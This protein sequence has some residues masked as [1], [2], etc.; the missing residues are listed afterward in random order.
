MEF[1]S[2]GPRNTV[3]SVYC[4]Y[5][6]QRKLISF[7]NL[8]SSQQRNDSSSLWK[9]C[10]QPS[11]AQGLSLCRVKRR[12]QGHGWAQTDSGGT[13]GERCWD[14]NLI[15]LPRKS[16]SG[17]RDSSMQNKTTSAILRAS[18][19]YKA[20]NTKIIKQSLT[21]H[22]DTEPVFPCTGKKIIF[23]FFSFL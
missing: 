9:S 17:Q 14:C 3:L 1:P 7:C 12:T 6:C 8:F 5:S 4:I 16:P 22:T 18:S 2:F 15:G 20:I 13:Q 21:Y 23:L 10:V 11:S 19:S